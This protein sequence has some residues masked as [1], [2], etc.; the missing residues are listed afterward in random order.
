[1]I[2]LSTNG[3]Q[4][5][6][7]VFY[8]YLHLHGDKDE[9]PKPLSIVTCDLLWLQDAAKIFA[10][11]GSLELFLCQALPYSHWNSP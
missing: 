5:K 4:R 3:H 6:N 10:E 11:Y 1:M 9:L 7:W 2:Q 8:E